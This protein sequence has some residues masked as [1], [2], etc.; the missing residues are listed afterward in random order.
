MARKIANLEHELSLHK[1]SSNYVVFNPAIIDIM[2]KYGLAGLA[3]AGAAAYG[4]AQQ[5]QQQF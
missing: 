3:P 2:K 5:D 4:A 1:P